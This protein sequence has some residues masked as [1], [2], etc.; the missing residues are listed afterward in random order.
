MT[1]FSCGVCGSPSVKLP[2]QLNDSAN[3]VCAGCGRLIATLATFRRRA[4][5]AIAAD[6][7]G[8]APTA[9]PTDHRTAAPTITRRAIRHAWRSRPASVGLSAVVTPD[10]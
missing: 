1:G 2:D 5:Q 10:E 3:V 6:G 7:V 9:V 8:Y 4:E